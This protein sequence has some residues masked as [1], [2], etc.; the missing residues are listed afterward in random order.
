MA[1]YCKLATK[2]KDERLETRKSFE[3]CQ[4]TTI[5]GVVFQ[6][7]YNLQLFRKRIQ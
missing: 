6:G 2:R 4:V 7:M 1:Q 5:Q 3:Q